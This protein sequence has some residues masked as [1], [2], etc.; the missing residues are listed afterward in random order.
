MTSTP[1]E[2]GQGAVNASGGEEMEA[3]DGGANAGAARVPP[4]PTAAEV[5]NEPD[6]IGEDLGYPDGDQGDGA[7]GG[8][9][10]TF[11]GASTGQAFDVNGTSMDHELNIPS[12]YQGGAELAGEESPQLLEQRHGG[13]EMD[14]G[15][16][17]TKGGGR[18]I[19]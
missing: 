17:R 16:D 2:E 5:E 12:T 9:M 6:V 11:T 1:K 19:H 15:V 4:D 13:D 8:D 18:C 14:A 10:P 3:V 7:G